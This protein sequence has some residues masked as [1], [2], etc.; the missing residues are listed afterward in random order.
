MRL[1]NLIISVAIC[2]LAGIV[3]SI[4]TFSAI[5]TW[6]ASLKKPD[7]SPPN[8]VF[9]PVWTTLYTLMGVSLFLVW[10]K[11]TE[12]K[13]AWP[14]IVFFLIHLVLNAFWSII[15]FGLKSPF[16]AFIAII[17]LWIM[18]VISIILF[19]RVNKTAGL[20]LLPYLIWVCFAS[21][22]NYSIWKLNS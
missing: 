15:F 10:Q 6:Y 7:L 9:G 5:P 11:R 12:V 17:V 18:I 3:G 16:W 2:Q 21:Y 22:L 20:L 8:W 4:F 14:A 1:L 13:L 19:Y